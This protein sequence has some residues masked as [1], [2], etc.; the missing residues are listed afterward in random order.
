MR[1][2]QKSLWMVICFAAWWGE[3]SDRLSEFLKLA[4][5]EFFDYGIRRLLSGSVFSE[6]EF[7]RF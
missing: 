2:R 4:S 3:I 7:L 6:S 1:A 5:E